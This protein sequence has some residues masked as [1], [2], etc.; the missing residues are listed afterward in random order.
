MTAPSPATC[1]S[2]RGSLLRLPPG[3]TAR[4]AAL[5]EPLAVA[6]HG[7][8]RSGVAPGDR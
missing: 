7:I 6:L 3:L 8:T 2:G 4:Q 1:W 5:A